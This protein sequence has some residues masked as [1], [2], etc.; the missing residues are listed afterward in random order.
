MR[1]S[2]P[3]ELP[4]GAHSHN[5]AGFANAILLELKSPAPYR[6]RMSQTAAAFHRFAIP[7]LVTFED[8]P[9]GLVRI[10]ITSPL[11]RAAVYLHGAHVT[12]F[13]P[14]GSE[15]ALFLSEKSTF[16]AGKPIRGGVPIIFP[17]FGPRAGHSDAPM[18]GFAR[19]SEWEI[20]TLD[21]TGGI[22]TIV[23]RLSASEATR[24][25]W[26]HDFILRHRITIG[27][28]LTMELEVENT[29]GE[30]F[31]FEEAL[32]TYLAVSD[33][34]AVSVSGLDGVEFIDKTDALARKTQD[35][36]PIKITAETDRVYLDTTSTCEIADPQRQR[37]IAVEKSGS[38]TT[39]VWNPWIAKA[40]A[41][42]D[43]GDDEWPRML[44]IETANAGENA[45][46]LAPGER[47]VMMARVVLA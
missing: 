7:G 1:H 33:V 15:P 37:Q 2:T 23:L 35:V 45:V 14:A 41:M 18:H 44:C 26:N 38:N 11:A 5:A 47:H 25:P 17:W 28:E 16:A 3:E 9:G 30:P 21:S 13:Q 12:D 43:F 46:T 6:P 42:A 8:A 19:T 4:A 31:Q 40:K 34:R 20:E 22:V 36:A 10:T 27:A 39:V 29:G 32:H 24:A